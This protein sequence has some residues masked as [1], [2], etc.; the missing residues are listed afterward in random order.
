MTED[1]SRRAKDI[2]DAFAWGDALYHSN[3]PFYCHCMMQTCRKSDF[4]SGKCACAQQ[5]KKDAAETWKKHV[6]TK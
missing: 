4:V 6:A 3:T 1:L 5:N 2:L